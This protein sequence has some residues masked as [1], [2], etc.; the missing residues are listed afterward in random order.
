MKTILKISSVFLLLVIMG[1]G[2]EDDQSIKDQSVIHLS[3]SVGNLVS[4]FEL[5]YGDFK[6]ISYDD[7]KL[8]LSIKNVIDSV[9]INCSLVDFANNQEAPLHVRV[10]S[11][12]QVNNTDELVKVASIPCGAISYNNT[13]HDIQDVK[14]LI[15][16]LESAPANSMD[17]T[18]FDN[19]FIGLFGEGSL[20]EDTP[21]RI[22]IAKV[23]PVKFDMPNA[24][25]EDYKFIFILT[26]KE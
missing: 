3:N 14:D 18:Y 4:I 16:E 1:A 2:C 5:K 8:N 12:L 6:E 10:Y 17:S 7:E 21:F 24:T 25:I 20:I 22:F 26:A 19:A 11:Y 15:D 9:T 23:D 13:G